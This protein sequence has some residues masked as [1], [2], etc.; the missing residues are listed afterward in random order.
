M[1]KFSS[2]IFHI[3]KQRNKKA[4]ELSGSTGFSVNSEIF[5]MM[6]IASP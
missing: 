6:S 3:I 2:G 1:A 4:S 5:Q